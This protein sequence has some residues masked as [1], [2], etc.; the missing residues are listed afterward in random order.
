MAKKKRI[1]GEEEK[2]F[3]EPKVKWK[4]SKAKSL[5]YKDIIEGRVPPDTV[6]PKG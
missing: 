2:K 3:K 5:L 1:V 6:G 4:K